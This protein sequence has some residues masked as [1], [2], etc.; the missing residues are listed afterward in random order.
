MFWLAKRLIEYSH[1]PAEGKQSQQKSGIAGAQHQEGEPPRTA[2]QDGAASS[3]RLP[4][5]SRWPHIVVSTCFRRERAEVNEADRV[6]HKAMTTAAQH[7]PAD[8]GQFGTADR[9]TRQHWTRVGLRQ[10]GLHE[11]KFDP[12]AQQ[13][14]D[15]RHGSQGLERAAQDRHPSGRRDKGLKFDRRRV[16]DLASHGKSGPNELPAPKGWR[17][18]MVFAY[19]GAALPERPLYPLAQMFQPP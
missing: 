10:A 15:P 6:A 4:S 1:D 2:V 5:G 17:P 3:P 12:V 13:Q 9:T 16:E 14:V 8:L 19:R 11:T 18:R 7:T